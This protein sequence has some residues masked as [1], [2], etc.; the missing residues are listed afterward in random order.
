MRGPSS[1]PITPIRG[2]FLHAALQGQWV[3][4]SQSRLLTLS[5]ELGVDTYPQFATGLNIAD[6]AGRRV[7]YQGETPGLDPEALAEFAATVGRIDAL[8][9]TISVLRPWESVH[10]DELDAQT[11]ESWIV[12]NTR[13][14]AVRSAMRLLS[15]A[16]LSAE[17]SQASAVCFMAYA[18]AAG[19]FEPLISTR[20]GAQDAL[21]DDGVWRLA[22]RM[23]AEL[24]P[25][26]VLNAPVASIAQNETGVTVAASNG[27]WRGRY[28]LVTAP[29]P[30]QAASNTAHPCRPCVTA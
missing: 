9:A 17:A 5:R 11:L 7:T 19:G 2:S 13:T 16:L 8:A 18:S 3:G 23:A 15:R 29:P 12:A 24:G 26:V 22:A 25:A 20:G 4:P 6:I 30:W 1:A 14:P 28:A 27:L 21:F 10:A